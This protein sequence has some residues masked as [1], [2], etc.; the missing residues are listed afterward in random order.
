MPFFIKVLVNLFE[1]GICTM[2]RY[3]LII[4]VLYLFIEMD[5]CKSAFS[6]RQHLAFAYTIAMTATIAIDDTIPR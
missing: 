2:L 4:S 6:L 3:D 1:T 5:Y